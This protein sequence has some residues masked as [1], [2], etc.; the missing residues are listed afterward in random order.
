MLMMSTPTVAGVY[1]AKY[2]VKYDLQVIWSFRE[3][4]VLLLQ[5]D[6]KLMTIGAWM[7]IGKVTVT[8]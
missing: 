8:G 3:A 5:L 1:F 2:T 7:R 4:R 6:R